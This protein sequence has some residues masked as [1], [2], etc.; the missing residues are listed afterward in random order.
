MKKLLPLLI[1][2]T[3]TTA[4]HA[5]ITSSVSVVSDYLIH[6]VT[7]TANQS[8]VQGSLDWSGGDFNAGTFVSNYGAKDGS[9][10]DLYAGYTY[11]ISED[12]SV[13]LSVA[14]YAYTKSPGLDT[15][16]YSLDLSVPY[17]DFNIDHVPGDSYGDETASTI[18]TVS[19][20][21]TVDEKS[22]LALNIAYGSTSY[23]DEDKT[24][25]YAY[26]DYKIGLARTVESLDFEIFYI[27][28]DRYVEGT[29]GLDDKTEQDD[30][31]VGIS[32]T[33]NF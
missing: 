21:L 6:G 28:T 10:L 14:N 30:A 13:G 7:Q 4:A 25:N 22:G 19:T 15:T 17:L 2:G 24:L 20:S 9:E 33:H 31:T 32:L 27:D 26:T 23:A 1:V 3:L 5:D 16:E 12:Y 11:E 18:F 29:E 8:A